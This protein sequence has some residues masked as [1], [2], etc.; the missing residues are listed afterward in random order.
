MPILSMPC[1]IYGSMLPNS[2]APR[3]LAAS[4]SRVRREGKHIPRAK[5]AAKQALCG[6]NPF[7]LSEKSCV[8][9]IQSPPNETAFYRDCSVVRGAAFCASLTSGKDSASP[10]VPILPFLLQHQHEAG[11]AVAVAAHVD[12]AAARPRQAVEVGR[13]LGPARPVARPGA[14]RAVPEVVGALVRRRVEERALPLLTETRAFLPSV[15]CV[16]TR[17]PHFLAAS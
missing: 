7:R 17:V 1:P 8:R 2:I 15:T 10:P 9:L 13:A 5:Q 3:K 16:L 14:R 4:E 6:V 11:D 12:L